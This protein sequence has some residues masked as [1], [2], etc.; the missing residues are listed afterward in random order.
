MADALSPLGLGGCFATFVLC[1]VYGRYLS[2]VFCRSSGCFAAIVVVFVGWSRRMLRRRVLSL[3]DAL[4]LL[5]WSLLD[6]PDGCFAVAA[7]VVMALRFLS[8]GLS[9]AWS[10]S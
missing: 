7:A 10:S 5:L 3:A 6:V 2:V 1:L 4:P 9:C 8:H